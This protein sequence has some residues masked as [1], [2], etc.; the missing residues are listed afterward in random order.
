MAKNI[1]IEA[2]NE[3]YDR[4]FSSL[5]EIKQEFNNEEILDSY[6]RYEGIIVITAAAKDMH[7]L[8][9]FTLGR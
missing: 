3:M 2:V 9:R 1:L 4:N 6:L 7:I 5:E 8:S